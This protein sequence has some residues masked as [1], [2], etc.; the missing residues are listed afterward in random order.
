MLSYPQMRWNPHQLHCNAQPE[1]NSQGDQALRAYK[2]VHC[3]CFALFTNNPEK[4][5]Q[6]QPN[7]PRSPQRPEQW[8]NFGLYFSAVVLALHL[9]Y[10]DSRAIWSKISAEGLVWSESVQWPLH[11]K[12]LQPISRESPERTLDIVLLCT[13]KGWGRLSSR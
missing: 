2:K 9:K 10:F 11:I 5:G 6:R 13:A 8:R 12:S 1:I 4:R 7:S 3:P